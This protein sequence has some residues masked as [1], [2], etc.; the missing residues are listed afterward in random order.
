M[1]I[2][3]K[4]FNRQR[5]KEQIQLVSEEINTMDKIIIIGDIHG[6]NIWEHIILKETD[7]SLAVFLGDYFDSYNGMYSTDEYANFMKILKYKDD[8]PDKVV[9]LIGNHDLHYIDGIRHCSR[10]SEQTKKLLG[11]LITSIIRDNILQA[12]KSLTSLFFV[13]AGISN[14]WLRDNRL[15]FDEVEINNLLKTNPEQFDFQFKGDNTDIFGNDTFQSPLWI[16]EEGL[17]KDSPYDIIQVVGHTQTN[18]T[19]DFKLSKINFCDSLEWGKY[20]TI[21][22]DRNCNWKFRMKRVM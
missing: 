19:E 8:N 6:R 5:S 1:G 14:T 16:R 2:L 9:L 17:L 12:T 21:E 3:R 4:L 15:K 13:H 10:Y 22:K 11:H 20:Y 18:P 7:Y